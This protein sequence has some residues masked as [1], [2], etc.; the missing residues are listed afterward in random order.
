MLELLRRLA[1]RPGLT[2]ELVAASLLANLLAL[3]PPLFVN[4]IR[5]S[6]RRDSS[7]HSF[8]RT[9]GMLPPLM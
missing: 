9:M 2:T 5:S 4:D 8:I 3:A 7:E 6:T 1:I